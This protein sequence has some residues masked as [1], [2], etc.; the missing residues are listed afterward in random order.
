V[1]VGAGL[2]AWSTLAAPGRAAPLAPGF[3][4]AQA[5]LLMLDPRSAQLSFGVRFGPTV[6]DHRNSVA[7]AQAQST[8]YGII[9]SALTATGCDGGAPFVS[10][11]QLPQRMQADSREP[12]DAEE[13]TV[14]EGPITQSV[15][16]DDAPFARATSRLAEADLPGLLTVRGARDTTSSGV[17]DGV[18]Q[19]EATVDVAELSILGGIVD[20]Q[21]LHWSAVHRSDGT[22]TGTFTIGRASVGGLPFPTQD[23]SAVVDA[24]NAVLSNLGVVVTPP[25]SHR[26]GDTIFVDPIKVGIAPNAVRDQVVGSVL[27]ALQPAR[28]ALFQVL[29][30]ATCDAGPAITVADILLGSLSGGGSFTAV[31]GGAQAERS[32][33]AELVTLGGGGAAGAGT[34]PDLSGGSAGSGL[35]GAGGLPS[36]GGPA[37]GPRIGG[38]GGTAT[39]AAGPVRPAASSTSGADDHAVPVAL[40]VL[41]LGGLLVEADRRKM[42]QA[43]VAVVPDPTPAEAPLA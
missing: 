19:V 34:G 8:D 18:A 41:A 36:L 42:R 22:P 12:A 39:T 26:E 31:I 1:V 21:G 35:G 32:G 5:Q 6:A 13:R 43:G 24:V 16:A 37:G 23:A 33:A 15:R 3:G 30:D 9:G 2:L 38:T 10:P 20:L 4:K 25:V 11:E 40:A 28:E 27:A 7:R 14:T 17:R 29:L